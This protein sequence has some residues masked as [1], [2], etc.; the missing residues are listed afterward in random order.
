M[1]T[2][3]EIN[4]YMEKTTYGL[5]T[6]KNAGRGMYAAY[7]SFF[8][9]HVP[10]PSQATLP[11]LVVVVDGYPLVC[12][13]VVNLT[14]NTRALRN[15]QESA[16]RYST[17]AEVALVCPAAGSTIQPHKPNRRMNLRE[18]DGENVVIWFQDKPCLTLKRSEGIRSVR[19]F[20]A[21]GGIVHVELRG[22]WLEFDAFVKGHEIT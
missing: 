7:K 18:R 15:G 6:A 19:A 1:R 17:L 8:F 16:D 3:A 14:A 5:L 21:Y 2:R 11:A 4:A 10:F 9:E 13:D 12:K 22:R 20:F